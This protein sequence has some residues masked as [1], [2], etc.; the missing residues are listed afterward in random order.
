VRREDVR[1]FLLLSGERDPFGSPAEFAEHITSIPG[2]VAG[3]VARWPRP[4]GRGQGRCGGRRLAG[5]PLIGPCA[6][7]ARRARRK[8]V[9]AG[10]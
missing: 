3:L 8:P 4:A 5:R 1:R 10:G 9:A 7:D 6:I 2:P